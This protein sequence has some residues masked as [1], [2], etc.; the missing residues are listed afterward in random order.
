VY[1]FAVPLVLGQWQAPVTTMRGPN[2]MRESLYPVEAT[3]DPEA[4]TTRVG[5]SWEDVP[6][7]VS[8]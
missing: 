5:W 8:P 3:Y 7:T 2:L 6:P 4:D 1:R